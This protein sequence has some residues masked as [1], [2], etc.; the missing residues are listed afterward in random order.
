M[1][2]MYLY[3]IIQCSCTVAYNRVVHM[4]EIV[5]YSTAGSYCLLFTSLHVCTCVHM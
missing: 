4:G 1:C 5:V 2:G 3:F